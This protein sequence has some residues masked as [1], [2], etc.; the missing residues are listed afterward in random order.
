V[1]RARTTCPFCRNGCESEVTFD[2]Q[3]R[4]EYPAD[5]KVNQGRLCPRGNS[6]NIVVDHPKRLGYPLLDGRE[7]SRDR[8]MKELRD[9]L[10]AVKPGEMAVVYGRGLTEAE[11]RQVRGFAKELGT[12]NIVCGHIEPENAFGRILDGAK[13]ATL[14]DVRQAK[15]T[16]LV[17]DVFSTSPVASGA[18]LDARYAD[19][20]NRVIVIDSLKT[21]QA[22]FAHLFLQTRPGGEA[23]ALLAIAGLLDS[24]L[25]GIDVDSCAVAAGVDRKQL[26]AAA[27]MLK[28]GTAG[29]V[30]SAMHLGR[31][32]FPVLHSLASQL[33]AVKSGKP[34]TGF[35][36]ARVPPGVMSFAALQ[37]AVAAGRI[38]GIAWFGGLYPYS[39]PSLWPELSTVPFRVCTSIFRPEKPLPGL[40][41]PAASE[42]EKE[43]TGRSYWGEVA[44]HPVAAVH[45]G[46]RT[47]TRILVDAGYTTEAKDEP[48]SNVGA[49]TPVKMGTD[50]LKRLPAG[51]TVL[52]GE[53]RAFG[54][55]GF[56]DTEEWLSINRSDAA[57]SGIG[58]DDS[59]EVATA[60]GRRVLAASLTDAVPAGVMSLGVNA[61]ANRALF[62]L[63][64]DETS[65]DVVAAPVVVSVTRAAE[66]NAFAAEARVD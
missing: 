48:A 63:S 41:L 35:A 22:G 16:L 36:E 4:M 24:G 20:K 2:Y 62:P 45:S 29:F 43:A 18:I 53:K 52:V 51:G 34:F 32:Q 56:H 40:V 12:S 38:S 47:V 28:P 59:V 6:A 11:V 21:R 8:A 14:D 55:G 60:A 19:R 17:G 58:D 54:I 44:R 7:V 49:E 23:F 33:V 66:R 57:E 27:A 46:A 31:V 5:A 15:V 61:H 3:Y 25:K 64:V 37:Q 1:T 13:A 10:G 42:L 65:G 30:G 9:G 39:Y 50:A 26:E